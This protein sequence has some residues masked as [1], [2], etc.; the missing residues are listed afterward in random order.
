MKGNEGEFEMEKYFEFSKMD[1][2]KCPNFEN[3]HIYP[4]FGIDCDHIL[5]L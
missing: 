3:R 2:N 5:I 1:K 4:D